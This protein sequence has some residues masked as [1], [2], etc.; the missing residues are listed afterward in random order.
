VADYKLGSAGS[1]QKLSAKG[2]SIHEAAR[3]IKRETRLASGKLV[4]DCI[5]RKRAWQLSWKR[6]A[7]STADT[8]DGGLGRDALRA[9]F[10]AGGSLNFVAPLEGGGSETTA[11]MFG[12]MFEEELLQTS[13]F[14]Q[15]RLGF[16]LEEV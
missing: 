3:E 9:L 16:E 15:W 1:E 10:D 13:P 6:L 11:V 14:W 7:G 12:E 8:E 5:A 4:R 2:M